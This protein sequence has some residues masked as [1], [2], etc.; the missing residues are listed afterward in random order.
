MIVFLKNGIKF[1]LLVF[2]NKVKIHFLKEKI[3]FSCGYKI[4]GFNSLMFDNKL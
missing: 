2:Y 1:N 4:N 3:D